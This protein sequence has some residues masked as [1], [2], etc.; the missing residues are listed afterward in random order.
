MT[1]ELIW[2]Q[3]I[4]R[5]EEDIRTR[6][7]TSESSDPSAWVEV[8]RLLL[9][10]ARTLRRSYPLLSLEDID[11]ILQNILL[12][13]Q[14]RDMMRRLRVA[15]SAAGYVAVIMRNAAIDLIRSRTRTVELT[16]SLEKQLANDRHSYDAG[17][18]KIG[19]I[20]PLWPALQR[21]TGEERNLLELRFW[22]DMT[23]AEIAKD[24][25]ITY[26][27]AAV[28]VFR[29]LHRLREHLI[30]SHIKM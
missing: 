30:R 26:S 22:R 20:S 9:I 17:A 3:L 19:E 21:L 6:K 4:P 12:K 23:I 18:E 5:L 11:D 24:L 7:G 25:G 16:S 13:L 10:Q 15:G 1:S 14:S 2:Y 8:S 28:R 27:A 29:V